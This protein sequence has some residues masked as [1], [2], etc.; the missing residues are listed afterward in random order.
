MALGCL[1][2]GCSASL[3]P[4]RAKKFDARRLAAFPYALHSAFR[5]RIDFR[6]IG[7]L[8][9][10]ARAQR[11]TDGPPSHADSRWRYGNFTLSDHTSGP[12]WPPT[13]AHCRGVIDGRC[14]PGV[15][16]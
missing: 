9:S 16:L 5:L 8:L 1:R 6:H 13:D 14:G 11:I 4:R 10:W 3:D 12:R 2:K 15:C 7:L